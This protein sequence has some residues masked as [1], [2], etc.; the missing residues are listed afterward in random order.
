MQNPHSVNV[1]SACVIHFRVRKRIGGLRADCIINWV[2]LTVNGS[3]SFSIFL[4]VC[5]V[6]GFKLVLVFQHVR[7]TI[8]LLSIISLYYSLM[9]CMNTVSRCVGTASCGG[10][11]VCVHNNN[12]HVHSCVHCSSST[13][14]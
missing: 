9:H 1:T 7:N 11:H 14:K 2:C 4:S 3:G 6:T 12:V 5:G 13:M 8:I 10:I